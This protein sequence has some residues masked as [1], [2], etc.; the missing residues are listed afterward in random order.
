MTDP[1]RNQPLVTAGA[2][3][4]VADAAAVLLH[5]RGG[6]A[7]GVVRLSEAFYRHGL[8]LLAPRADRNRWYPNS[9]LAP[10]ETNEPHLS[11]ALRAVGDAV[12]TATDAGLPRGQVLVFGVSQGACLAAEF[13]VRNPVRYGGVVVASGGLVGPAGTDREYEGS[14]D[15]TPVLVTGSE[16]DSRVP[17]DRVRETAAAFDRLDGDV[18]ER[19]DEG[20]GHGVSDAD[21]AVVGE[22]VAALTA[23]ERGGRQ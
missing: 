2:P 14:L 17:I 11:S 7:D 6:T 5:G 10:L 9:F 13:V 8:A 23:D 18:T 16:G 4:A 22:M 15:G 20:T 21:L 3:L 1:H 12:E 19:I